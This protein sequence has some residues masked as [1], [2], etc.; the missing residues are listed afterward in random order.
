MKTRL[1][2][3]LVLLFFV[4]DFSLLAQEFLDTTFDPGTGVNGFVESAVVQPDG[5][6]LICGNFTSFNGVPR[7]YM[8][9][10]NSNGSLDTDFVASPNYWVRFMALQPDGKIVIGGFFTAVGGQPRN[11]VARVNTDGSVDTTFNPGAGC[12]G[13]MV[14][15]DPTDPFLFAI[16]LQTDGKI[17]IGGNFTNYNKAPRMGVARLNSDG[18]LDSNFNVGSG[19]DSWVR[20]I[21]VLPNE[22]IL[23]SGWFQNYNSHGH[24][25]MVRLNPDGSADETFKTDIGYSTSIYSMAQQSDGKLIVGG[26]S[27]NTNSPFQQ[28][29]VRLNL[30]GSYDRSF[31]PGG[32][33][34]NE[35]VESVVLQPDGKILIAGYFSQYNGTQLKNIA[36]LNS[37]GSLDTGF[38]AATDNWIWTIAPQNDGKFLITGAFS[39]VDGA[40]RNGIARLNED[41]A[42]PP[43]VDSIPPTVT[44]ASPNANARVNDPRITGTATDD[45]ELAQVLYRVGTNE[46]AAANGTTSWAANASLQP[47]NNTVEVKSVD[48]AGNESAVESRTFF[49]VPGA[50]LP[51]EVVGPGSTTLTNGQFLQL[52]KSYTIRAIPITGNS[53][54][55]WSGSV[56]SS[57]PT[58]KFVM[59]S[60]LVLQANFLTNIFA[61]LS[62]I[63]NGIFSSSN[64]VTP[65]TAGFLTI[66]LKNSG[67]FSGTI[68]LEGRRSSF[69]SKFDSNGVVQKTISRRAKPALD[70]NLQLD[71]A[72]SLSGTI[73]QNGESATVLA[74]RAQSSVNS[75]RTKYTL[76]IPPGEDPA[77]SPGGYGYG[78]AS[79][80]A[81]GKIRFRGALGDGTVLQ[82]STTAS[83]NGRWPFYASLYRGKGVIL[84]WLTFTN[85][86][87]TDLRGESVSWIKLPGVRGKFYTNGFSLAGPVIGSLYAAPPRGSL[88]ITWTSGNI[89]FNGGNL[90]ESI[91]NVV[92][93]GSRNKLVVASSNKTMIAIANSSGLLNGSF[94]PPNTRRRTALKGALLQKQQFSAGTFLGATQSGNFILQGIAPTNSVL[95]L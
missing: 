6:I 79:V 21:L 59:S 77:T 74:E 78:S 25:R 55:G 1:I 35:K 22:Q 53:F 44:I 42:P 32:S 19:L 9:R 95:T 63:Y 85:E 66:K 48:A 86:P 7:S 40:S 72:G 49:Y 45:V 8:A 18:S 36:R 75:T 70:L 23:L 4:S 43:P 2:C 73:S 61:P 27:V 65:A 17:I 39:K 30:D 83:E 13:R 28:E 71:P 57:V 64:G 76:L 80:D 87:D 34:A 90:T 38:S 50:P 93:S 81:K 94:V 91:T 67:A 62:G 82:Q 11:R 88:P 37:D 60:N 92:T 31:N 41:L 12:E 5:K 47:G 26:H 52:G 69:S 46:F 10:L 56:T 20:S 16:G 15:A 14:P 24:D 3:L 54:G 84:G 33:G 68:S 51:L 29:V 89:E 58:L